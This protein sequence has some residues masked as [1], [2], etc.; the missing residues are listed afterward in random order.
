[1]PA[2]AGWSLGSASLREA[3]AGLL[4]LSCQRVRQRAE[5]HAASQEER[6]DQNASGTG[7]QTGCKRLFRAR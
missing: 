1:M 6:S 2:G 7:K 5:L 3:L 4:L